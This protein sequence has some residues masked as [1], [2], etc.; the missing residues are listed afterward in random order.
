LVSVV[1]T[2]GD[3]Y[4]QQTDTGVGSEFANLMVGPGV[5]TITQHKAGTIGY[6]FSC[7]REID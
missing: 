4:P 3:T 2:I 7:K 1:S 6:L 5:T